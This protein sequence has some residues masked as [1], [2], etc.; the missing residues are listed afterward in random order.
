[1]NIHNLCKGRVFRDAIQDGQD[2]RLR[3]MDGFELVVAW[4]NDGPEPKAFAHGI[5][6]AEML[7]HPQFRYVSGKTVA[8][9]Y[10]DAKGEK[11]IIRFTD[12][13]ELRSSFGRSGPQV[14]GVDVKVPI[15]SPPPALIKAGNL[16]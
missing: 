13:H 16:R 14:D 11:L 12:G 1:M 2:F 8:A 3:F 15:Q 6:T 10:T 7:I 9:V 5:V 4:G